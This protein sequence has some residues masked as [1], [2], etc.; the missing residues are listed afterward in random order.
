MGAQFQFERIEAKTETE[1][2]VAFNAVITSANPL[3]IILL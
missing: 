1:A 2:K 3:P